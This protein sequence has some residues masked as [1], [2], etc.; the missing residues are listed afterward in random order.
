MTAFHSLPRP[1]TAVLRRRPEDFLV[2]EIPATLPEGEGEHVWLSIRKRGMNTDT[3]AGLLGR[4]ADVPRRAV[5]YAGR[6]DRHAVT[7]QWFSVHLPGRE[8]PAWSEHLPPEVEILESRRHRRKLQTGHLQGNRF[9]LVLRQCEGDRDIAQER[10]TVMQRRGVPN[11]FGA[12]RFGR[13]GGNI[14]KAQALFQGSLQV[15]DQKLRG[16][17]LSAAR[18]EIF[19][20]VLAAR[21]EDET[22]D[23]ALPGDALQLD[24]RGSFFIYQEDDPTV[25]DRVAEQALHVTGPLWGRG[26]LPTTGAVAAL[27][28]G[29]AAT[30]PVLAQGLEAAGLTQERRALRIRPQA[31]TWTWEDEQTLQLGFTLPAGAFA[32]TLVEVFAD[33]GAGGGEG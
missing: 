3:V 20:Q 16:I 17:Y 26:E 27:E 31:L 22:W 29:I 9:V 32:T 28:S 1:L 30:M 25:P 19:N 11:F 10:L 6:K 4:I 13:D 33:T 24:G 5:G 15:R 8:A 2:E 23:Q 18:S 14:A 12:Q 21:L 7:T